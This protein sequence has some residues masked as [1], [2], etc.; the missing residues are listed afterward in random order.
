MIRVIHSVPVWLRQTQ[1]WIHTQVDCVPRDRVENHVV[2]ESTMNLDQFPVL[3]LHDFRAEPLALR[4]LD[5]GLRR[6]RLR[7]H[8]GFLS[9]VAKRVGAHLIHSHFGDVGWADIGAARA[10]GARHMVTFYGYDISSL[11]AQP[12]WRER[13]AELF[14]RAAL[15]LCEGPHMAQR[16]VAT[17]C[18]APKVRVHHLGVRLEK[19]PFRPR[20]WHP[21]Q[22]LRVLIAATFTEKKGI[23]YALAALADLQDALE[24]EATII[25]DAPDHPET[26][27]E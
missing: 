22:R 3:R 17:G 12:G 1:T 25:G 6:L 19:I 4:L 10:A 2:C 15:I 16:V 18:P 9:R 27:A 14:D 7:R 13:L 21:G 5:R 11:P 26:R 23:P 24:F 20:Q 8:L